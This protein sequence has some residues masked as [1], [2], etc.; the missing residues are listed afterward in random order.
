[1]L[2]RT[3]VHARG[4]T[5]SRKGKRAFSAFFAV[6]I[7]IALLQALLSMTS[8]PSAQAVSI[9]ECP[10]GSS[11]GEGSSSCPN[12]ENED[13]VTQRRLPSRLYRG[14]SR[15]PNDIFRQGFTSWGSNDDIVSHVQ[16]D[17][18]YNSNYI[19][20]TGTLSL[21][22]SFARNG[23][24][25]RL[26]SLAAQPR[27]STGRLAFY[28]LIPVL[29]QLLT[30]SCISGQVTSEAFVYVIDPVWARN[31]LYVPDQIRGNAALH[32]RYAYQDE[33]AYVHRIP[34]EAITGVRIYRMTGH[35][36]NRE[37]DPRTVTFTYSRFVGNP[38]HA[39][40]QILYNPE[41]DLGSNFGFHTNLNIPALPTNPFT[42]GC[43]TINFC[44]N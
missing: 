31:A 1:M 41:T 24:L 11:S 12:L 30:E 20:T 2:K 13:L 26:N 4:K 27:C 44:R 21:S 22:E 16:G 38:L 5:R 3:A 18:N 32:S 29:G 7:A 23:G 15:L 10:G 43:S 42:R 14:D 19:P 6:A 28:A 35:A 25:L 36:N 37:I 34:R 17:R 9:T 40:A 33:W 8:A 39:Q